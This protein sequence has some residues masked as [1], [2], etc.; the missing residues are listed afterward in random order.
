LWPALLDVY[1]LAPVLAQAQFM[2]MQI[3]LLVEVVGAVSMKAMALPS[4]GYRRL[5]S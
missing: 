3:V 2:T 4:Q 5:A 1:Q